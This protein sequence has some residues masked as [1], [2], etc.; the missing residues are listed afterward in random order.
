[1]SYELLS[2]AMRTRTTT[3][4]VLYVPGRGAV[5][6]RTELATGCNSCVIVHRRWWN[7]LEL[8]FGLNVTKKSHE[9]AVSWQNDTRGNVVP[10]DLESPGRVAVLVRVQKRAPTISEAKKKLCL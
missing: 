8:S 4:A 3:S 5:R 6:I 1:M 7:V 10:R 9:L 2:N